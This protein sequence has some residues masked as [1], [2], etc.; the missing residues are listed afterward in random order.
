MDLETISFVKR[1]WGWRNSKKSHPLILLNVIFRNLNRR[2][3][4]SWKT[5]GMVYIKIKSDSSCFKSC[6]GETHRFKHDNLTLLIEKK[7]LCPHP[8]AARIFIFATFKMCAAKVI[9]SGGSSCS[10][11]KSGLTSLQ[12]GYIPLGL[13]MYLKVEEKPTLSITSTPHQTKPLYCWAR[14]ERTSHRHKEPLSCTMRP[15]NPCR[16]KQT[17]TMT[18]TETCQKKTPRLETKPART[19]D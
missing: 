4:H 15:L 2:F 7:Q 9:F 16:P 8:K 3:H 5:F 12:S 10:E 1:L 19:A 11:P 6:S 13:E 17:Q 14:S 18:R